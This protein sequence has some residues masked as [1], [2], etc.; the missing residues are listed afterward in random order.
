MSTR[1]RMLPIIISNKIFRFCLYIVIDSLSYTFGSHTCIIVNN[2]VIF[3]MHIILYYEMSSD[4][5]HLTRK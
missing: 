5:I 3:I 2:Q 1:V 4:H